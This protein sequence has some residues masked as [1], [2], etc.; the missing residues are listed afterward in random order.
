[1]KDQEPLA[2]C[3]DLVTRTK[4]LET[5]LQDMEEE[6]VL[7][8]KENFEF[9]KQMD[10]FKAEKA[11]NALLLADLQATLQELETGWV[12]AKQ[13]EKEM[14]VELQNLTESLER[15]HQEDPKQVDSE[16]IKRILDEI[17]EK[18]KELLHLRTLAGTYREQVTALRAQLQEKEDENQSLEEQQLL[19][20][21]ELEVLQQPLDQVV[22]DAVH[23][24]AEL[25]LLQ[26]K[27]AT[28]T[29]RV[30]QL[31][32]DNLSLEAKNQLL[33]STLAEI[34]SSERMLMELGTPKETL[35]SFDFGED[36]IS[37]IGDVVNK[38]LSQDLHALLGLD[39]GSEICRKVN[40]SSK[41][42]VLV[43][44]P[45]GVFTWVSLSTPLDHEEA[46]ERYKFKEVERLV[47]AYEPDADVVLAVSHML[48]LLDR[49]KLLHKS[50]IARS[51]EITTISTQVDPEHL[52][53]LVLRLLKLL[54]SL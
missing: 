21:Q 31:E 11:K 19:V 7:L 38:S 49:A 34:K 26:S 4:D 6:H 23:K 14:E 50:N 48:C 53:E 52:Q 2:T 30:Q 45:K 15:A 1:M 24:S 8:S 46:V 3:E 43:R 10:E 9:L 51:S 40:Y 28:E 33:M 27:F 22:I 41:E 36:P 37:S 17:E 16:Q 18:D 39:E 12:H 42:W 20:L 29:Q 54:P 13:R 44:L 5:Q 47:H 32:T 35:P 25:A